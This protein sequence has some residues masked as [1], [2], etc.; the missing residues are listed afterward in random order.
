MKITILLIIAS[1]FMN[2]SNDNSFTIIPDSSYYYNDTVHVVNGRDI[3]YDSPYQH[4]REAEMPYSL[5][6]LYAFSC[7]RDYLPTNYTKFQSPEAMYS[8]IPDTLKGHRYTYYVSQNYV[9]SYLGGFKMEKAKFFG[10]ILSLQNDTI[11][12]SSIYPN[13]EADSAGFR[14]GDKIIAVD[15]FALYGDLNV[16][17]AVVNDNNKIYNFAIVR[18]SILDTIPAEKAEMTIPA[19]YSDSLTSQI[20]YVKLN[21]FIADS[22]TVG[23]ST[24]HQFYNALQATKDFPVT[25]I[26]IRGNGGGY[27]SEAYFCSDFFLTKGDSIIKT[28]SWEVDNWET[29]EGSFKTKIIT[30]D[31]DGEFKER[32]FV[33][34][35]DGGSASAS[36]ILLSAIKYNTSIEIVGTQTYGKGIGQIS[37]NALNGAMA[38]ITRLQIFMPN[39]YNYQ[40][41]G[42]TPDYK[43]DVGYEHFKDKQLTKAIEVANSLI[44][45]TLQKSLNINANRFDE[46]NSFKKSYLDFPGLGFVGTPKNLIK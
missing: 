4:E 37:I 29:L 22:N 21:S 30:T 38:H 11:F 15:K 34:L 2:C 36:E 5:A 44:S 13:S 46:L 43:V 24:S 23:G 6:I 42:F 3:V 17:K 27:I 25:I 9:P 10:M 39:G 19:S 45:T 35:A 12:I 8:S 41:I 28:V 40:H 33:F 26:D 1:F 32:K 14:R 16:Y 18:D 31:H 7:Y 20:G